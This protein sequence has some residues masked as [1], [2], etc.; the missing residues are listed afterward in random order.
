MSDMGTFR[1][2][3][4]I[5]N[6]AYPGTRQALTNVLVDTGSE[7]TWIPASVLEALGIIES[8]RAHFRLAD[9]RVIERRVGIACVYA[10]GTSTGDDVVFAEPGDSLLLGARSL[11]GLNVHVDPVRKMLV[12]AGPAP[13]AAAA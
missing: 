5:E 9:G 8:K 4:E 1:T 7:L 12:D 6:P 13:A 10:G 3:I 2:N 11:E